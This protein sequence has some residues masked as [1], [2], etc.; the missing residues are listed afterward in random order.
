MLDA[1]RLESAFSPSPGLRAGV[2]GGRCGGR[3][4]GR[5]ST[6]EMG[7]RYREDPRLWVDLVEQAAGEDV[8]LV[9]GAPAP[10]GAE[11]GEAAERLHGVS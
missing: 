7:E 4:P 3:Q 10:E 9:G 8:T 6:E 11:R 1:S 2:A 5:R